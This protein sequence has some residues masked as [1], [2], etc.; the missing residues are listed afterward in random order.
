LPLANLGWA[1]S[2]LQQGTAA[3]VFR[4]RCILGR[5]M[6]CLP[7]VVRAS[8]R[9]SSYEVSFERQAA[10]LAVEVVG[11][12]PLPGAGLFAPV[13][14]VLSLAAFGLPRAA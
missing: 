10:G 8:G 3:V 13:L 14:R 9:G 1:L 12:R 5:R 6:A 11:K 7:A 2:R 4:G